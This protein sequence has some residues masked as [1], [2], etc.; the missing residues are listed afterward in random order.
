MCDK[1]NRKDKY[2]NEYRNLHYKS[3]KSWNLYNYKTLDVLDFKLNKL[4]HCS[5]G[6][7]SYKSYLT[8]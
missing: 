2:M 3:A 8:P 6:L 1:N 5:I 7:K 4:C